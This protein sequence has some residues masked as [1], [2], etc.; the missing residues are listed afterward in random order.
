MR[1]AIFTDYFLPSIGG[2]Q[3]SIAEQA[4]VLKSA[5]H[6][7]YIVAPRD[8]AR[9]ADFEFD[10][11]EVPSP[12]SLRYGD[13][14]HP[15]YLSFPF[16]TRWLAKQLRQRDIDIIHIESEFTVGMLGLSI[17]RKMELPIVYTT[18]TL[19][20][21]QAELGQFI[22]TILGAIVIRIVTT[23]SRRHSPV[24]QSSSVKTWSTQSYLQLVLYFAQNVDR[25]IAPSSHLK[26]KL[27]DEGI[28]TNIYVIPNAC[29]AAYEASVLPAIPNLL[30]VGRLSPEKQ[31]MLFA[32]ALLI[33]EKEYGQSQAK[34]KVTV[35]GEGEYRKKMT[36]VLANHT[37]VQFTGNLPH[38]QMSRYYQEATAL[39]ITSVGFDNQ[40]MI[41]V[42]ALR[43]G[44]GVIYI[45]P[46]L[47]EGLQ[48]GTAVR[49]DD[50]SPQALAKAMCGVVMGRHKAQSMSDATKKQFVIFSPIQ[51]RK[52][53]EIVYDE[54]YAT[55][56]RNK[57]NKKTNLV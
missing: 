38:E 42:E 16:A 11:I 20:W 22:P 8:H 7:V 21:K 36:E 53:V 40:P 41:I 34:Y 4:R 52:K 17:A 35:I 30:W 27:V 39:V 33:L 43:H 45:D 3:T 18:H 5:G 12:F 25:V 23:L 28:E 10:T 14:R 31:P 37:E 51:Y 6:A 2:T 9:G 55:K 44:R 47:S 49:A 46:E 54:L 56:H 48:H 50:T 15:S 13:H 57:S 24:V 26:K 1:I 29:A 19:L 32:E